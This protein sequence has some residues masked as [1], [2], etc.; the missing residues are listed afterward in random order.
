MAGTKG[1]DSETPAV[2]TFK[3][4]RDS[5]LSSDMDMEE[6]DDLDSEISFEA[7]FDLN[8]SDQELKRTSH[9]KPTGGRESRTNSSVKAHYIF[10]LNSVLLPMSKYY[11][12]FVLNF[13]C[14]H[15]QSP[16]NLKETQPMMTSS[17]VHCHT[18][19]M[20]SMTRQMVQPVQKV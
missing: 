19:S 20:S 4:E 1:K 7:D 5:E 16:V 12:Q 9:V 18:L 17:S 14:R 6:S 11:T 10:P 13:D 3:N 15:M 2:S 8:S